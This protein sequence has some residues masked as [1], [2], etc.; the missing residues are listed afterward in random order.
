MLVGDSTIS[1]ASPSSYH[2]STLS[3]TTGVDEFATNLIE[4]LANELAKEAEGDNSLPEDLANLSCTL[5]N[6]S[7]TLGNMS[8]SNLPIS[9]NGLD[10][11]ATGLSPAPG[12]RFASP[13]ADSLSPVASGSGL[14]WCQAGLGK[15]L[16]IVILF[17]NILVNKALC[18]SD[19]ILQLWNCFC[20]V[21]N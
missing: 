10:L 20:I 6:L 18:K 16:E 21:I 15:F 1:P 11:P 14:V 13:G 12:S 8:L 17:L 9:P 7:S 4:R 5:A 3:P 19:Y 2:S